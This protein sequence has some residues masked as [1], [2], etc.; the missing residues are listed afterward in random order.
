MMIEKALETIE[1]KI[2]IIPIPDI[3]DSAQWVTHVQNLVPYFDVVYTGNPLVKEL[4]EEKNIAVAPILI[5]KQIS[6]S[7]IRA[8]KAQHS[9]AWKAL[10]PDSLHTIIDQIH[11]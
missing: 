3:H 10:V 6:G 7:Q 11:V 4:F 2:T 8:D 1:K 5:T 9:D